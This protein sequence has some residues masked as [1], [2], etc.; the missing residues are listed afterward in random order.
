MLPVAEYE[1]SR[2][3]RNVVGILSYD[4]LYPF[5]VRVVGRSAATLKNR[6]MRKVCDDHAISFER[7]PC[8][9]A[10]PLTRDSSQ[11]E[12]IYFK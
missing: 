7:N 2:S 8:L 5:K 4:G 12:T 10:I 3:G 6:Y 11:I 9:P 1:L